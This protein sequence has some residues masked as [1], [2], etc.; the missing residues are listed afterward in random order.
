MKRFKVKMSK[1]HKKRLSSSARSTK[2]ANVVA[3]TKRGGIRL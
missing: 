1:R 3:T 2:A